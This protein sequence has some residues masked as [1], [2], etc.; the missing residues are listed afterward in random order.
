[1][2]VEAKEARLAIG[3][4]WQLQIDLELPF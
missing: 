3:M 4:Q 1:M 2:K